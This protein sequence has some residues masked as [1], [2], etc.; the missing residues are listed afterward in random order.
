MRSFNDSDRTDRDSLSH[1]AMRE[2]WA[3]NIQDNLRRVGSELRQKVRTNGPDLEVDLYLLIGSLNNL[4]KEINE[5]IT[6][7]EITDEEYFE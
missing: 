1:P 4:V 3:E 7:K 5:L 6:T 2:E